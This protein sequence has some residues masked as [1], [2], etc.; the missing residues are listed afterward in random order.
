MFSSQYSDG[1]HVLQ[2]NF[3][4]KKVYRPKNCQKNYFFYFVLLFFLLVEIINR[5]CHDGRVLCTRDLSHSRDNCSTD[6]N[7]STNKY[8]FRIRKKRQ[9]GNSVIKI[10]Y[11]QPI[12]FCVREKSDIFFY[13]G[14]NIVV[15][16][17][18]SYTYHFSKV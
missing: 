17:K 9:R 4:I 14:I 5:Q 13:R 3:S 12:S 1:H 7:H 10:L 8:R 15:T 2:Q 11:M 6:K 18:E 16:V